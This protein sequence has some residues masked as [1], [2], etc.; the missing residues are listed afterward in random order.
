[1]ARQLGPGEQGAGVDFPSYRNIA[2][3]DD[4][5]RLD[6]VARDQILEQQN[7]GLDLRGRIRRPGVRLLA[8]IDDL[9]ADR[10]RIQADLLIPPALAGMPGAAVFVHQA[11]HLRPI[12]VGDQVVAADV[13]L[14]KNAQRRIVAEGGVVQH[15]DV[16]PAALALGPM[17][18]VDAQRARSADGAGAERGET[19]WRSQPLQ[20]AHQR[21]PMPARRH[22]PAR[23]RKMVGCLLRSGGGLDFQSAI[24]LAHIHSSA[25]VSER[26]MHKRLSPLSVCNKPSYIA[27]LR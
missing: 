14:G 2:V 4:V 11:I 3:P 20:P 13:L 12:L 25:V 24:V 15:Q 19:D 26:A 10:G 8:R 7:Q 5:A 6:P 1:M 23:K 18:G 9:D 17:A 21:G 27:M 16:D 22:E